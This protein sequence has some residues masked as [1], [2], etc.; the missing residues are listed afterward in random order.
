MNNSEFKQDLQSDPLVQYFKAGA[1]KEGYLNHAHTKLQ[2]KD[3]SDCISYIFP[4]FDILYLFDQ[5]SG[6]MKIR[7]DILHVGNLR[8]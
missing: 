4:E 5:S 1:N 3:V 7:M 2:L 6:Y 8:R